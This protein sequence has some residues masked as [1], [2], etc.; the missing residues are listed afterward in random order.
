M[1][2]DGLA[3]PSGNLWGT[4]KQSGY[5]RNLYNLWESTTVWREEWAKSDQNPAGKPERPQHL[6]N[7]EDQLN[8]NCRENELE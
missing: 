7:L 1:A 4:V 8:K 6:E 2:L 3:N 5:Q